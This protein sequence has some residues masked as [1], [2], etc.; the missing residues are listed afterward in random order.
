MGRKVH[1]VGFRLG[2]FRSWD[3]QW[4]ADRNFATLVIEDAHLRDFIRTWLKNPPGQSEDRRGGGRR[5]YSAGVSRI[6]IRRVQDMVRINIFTSRPG[7]VIGRGG[8]NREALQDALTKKFGKRIAVDVT[9]ITSPDLDAYLVARSVAD[10]IERRVS[11]RR[12][13]KSA[14]ERCLRA[15]AEGVKIQVAGRLGGREMARTEYE[16]EGRVPLQTLTADIDYGQAVA[17]TTY[18]T[19]GIKTWIHRGERARRASD[20]SRSGPGGEQLPAGLER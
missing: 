7:V 18:G 15:W 2:N 9:E 8:S 14:A 4:Y 10:Q 13:M 5:S 6:V 1:P 17:R 19:I 12:A 3:S 16:I 11:F 20:A